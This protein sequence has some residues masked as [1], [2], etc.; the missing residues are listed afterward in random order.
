MTSETVRNKKG[1]EIRKVTNEDGYTHWEVWKD[2]VQINGPFSEG[3]A[4][5]AYND[6]VDDSDDDSDLIMPLKEK[7]PE[8]APSTPKPTDDLTM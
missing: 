7:E 1:V 5:R 2:G 3:D 6:L 4:E 8:I